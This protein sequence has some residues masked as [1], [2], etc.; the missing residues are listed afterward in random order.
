MIQPIVEGHSEVQSVPVLLR[1][2]AAV[3][4]VYI[5]VAI[6]F[7]FQRSQ[8]TNEAPLRRA[9]D[10]ARSHGSSAILIVFD[11]DDD[12]PKSFGPQIQ[13]LAERLAGPMPCAVV[14]ANREFEAWFLASL[15][16]LRG[17]RGISSSASFAG[18]P[19]LPRGAK[20][21]LEEHMAGRPYH[22]TTDQPALTA[23]FDMRIAYRRSRSFRRMVSAFARIV[24][25]AASG[26]WPPRGW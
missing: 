18:D 22:T 23:A 11:G 16:S 3:S 8:L 9:I 13:R 21:I 5:R 1:R 17:A 7:R 19:D 6:P 4:S 24:P 20:E 14:I 10:L 15:E 26:T 25:S 12:C 2:M